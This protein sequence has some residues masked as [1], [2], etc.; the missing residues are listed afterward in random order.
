MPLVA[1]TSSR[2]ACRQY[3]EA[4]REGAPQAVQVAD[5]WH[6][7]QNLRE[8]A[9]RCLTRQH[10]RVEQATT[11]VAQQQLLEY[12]TTAGAVSMR[13]SRSAKD[14]QQ[15]RAKRYALSE[16]VIA[17]RQQGLSHKRIARALGINYVTVRTFLRA[18]TFP[19][20]AK[21][22]RGSQL[23]PYIAALHQRWL[24][25][26]TNPLQL[27]H[28]LVA[29]GYTG[30]PRMVRRYVERFAQRLQALTPEQ[31]T[32]FLQAETT[33]KTPSV[34]CVAFWLLKPPQE[35]TPEQETVITRLCE[36]SAEIK[37]VWELSHTFVQMV[38]PRQNEALPAWLAHAEQSA[39]TEMRSV[40]TGLRQDYAAVAAALVYA[41]S[42]GQVEGQSNK[43]KL[44]KRQMYGRA[45]LDLLR[46]RLLDRA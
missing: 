3:A 15:N 11:H 27:W 2:N 26:C 8:A 43:R 36:I 33:L 40:A 34:R 6:L 28:E 31:R 23:D 16:Q 10:A 30:T 19:A 7:R 39:V 44:L 24:Q 17:L 1:V 32:Q 4:A 20:R 37:S 13:S 46:V 14:L 45:K 29:P 35:L 12:S 9:Q 21:Y 42:N 22:R 41:W 5:R 18:G 38:Q 25:G